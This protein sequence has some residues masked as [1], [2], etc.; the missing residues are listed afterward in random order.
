MPDSQPLLAAAA[1]FGLGLSLIVAIGAQNS[2]V[3]RQGLR[4]EHLG[5]ICVVCTVSDWIL[6]AAGVGGAATVLAASPGLLDAVRYGGAAFLLGYGLLAA[7]RAWH[8]DTLRAD[9]Y[10]EGKTKLRSTLATCLGLTWLNPHVYLDT[11]VV[12]GSIAATHGGERVWFGIG[13]GVASTVWFFALGYGAALLRPLFARPTSWRV[14]D[15]AIAALMIVLAISVAS[16]D[17]HPSSSAS[18]AAA[19]RQAPT[20]TRPSPDRKEHPDAHL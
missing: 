16:T 3:L 11:V 12:L 10:A 18:H 6:I 5:P 4:G 9:P 7:R 19:T 20:V 15:G 14:L 1:G 13:A 17:L 8:P 2:F